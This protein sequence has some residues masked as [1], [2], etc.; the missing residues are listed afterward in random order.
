MSAMQLVLAALDPTRL[1]AVQE[2]LAGVGVELMTVC[3]AL[4]CDTL[5][6]RNERGAKSPP[7]L[8]RQVV[9]EIAVNDDFL[10]RT[11]Q[12]IAQVAR[13]SDGSVLV[14]PLED[15]VRL[16]DAVRGAEAVS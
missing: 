5:D 14:L 4:D 2:A 13:G 3:D 9:L 11:V 12:T 7:K 1:H 6:E 8:L 16:S 15:V 10:E